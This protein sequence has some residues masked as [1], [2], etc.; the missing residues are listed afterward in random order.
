M[1]K[2][3]SLALLGMLCA[4]L[5]CCT[6]SKEG[7]AGL[8]DDD[9][10]LLVEGKRTF[11]IGSYYLPKEAAPYRAMA[12]S[13]YNLIRVNP[14]A[15]EL[16][17]AHNN[18]LK[19]WISIGSLQNQDT[20]QG[21]QAYKEKIRPLKEHPGLLIWETE[22]E[23]AWRWNTAEQRV[24]AD[25]MIKS[26]NALKSEDPKHLVYVNH[27]PTNLVST[28][29]QYNK[30]L[31]I[32]AC[33]IYPVIPKGIRISYALFPDGMQGDLL[34]TYI[35]QVG[36][37]ADKMR[38]VTG[39]NRPVFMVLQGFSWEMLREAN[40]RDTAM[41]KYP[42]FQESRFMAYESI[43]HGANGI[44]YWGTA[45][46]PPN[47]PFLQHLNLVTK[48]LG[49]LQ[50]VLAARSKKLDIDLKYHE[51]GYSVD[52]GIEI[53]AKQGTDAVY[54][55]TAN[56]DKNPAKVTLSG[57]QEYHRAIVLFENR[58]LRMDKGTITDQYA[59][60]DVHVFKLEK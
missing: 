10:M 11:I 20:P 29:Q 19:A 13:G 22:D 17:S 49:G 3:R 52:R 36:Q 45:Y 12:Q 23:P 9:G 30:A 38:I 25:V 32:A 37:Y 7:R 40:D 14:V 35:S 47:E 24:S 15:A 44:V 27:A 4:T 51:L 18:G 39:K 56:A 5:S 60:F 41:V 16:D 33:D 53:L 54:L 46:T 42:S 2:R 28:L 57:L 48:E 59:P 50:S 58:E 8:Y 31:D 43:I 21:L 6:S 1:N 34:N 55:I 26:Y